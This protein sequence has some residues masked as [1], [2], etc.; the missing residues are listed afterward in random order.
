MMKSIYRHPVFW[1]GIIFFFSCS[2]I[3]LWITFTLILKRPT[4]LSTLSDWVWYTFTVIGLVG[5][6]SIKRVSNGRSN[7][8]NLFNK[9]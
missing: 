9:K 4:V 6:F 3:A 1:I 7:F 5:A 8:R 2:I